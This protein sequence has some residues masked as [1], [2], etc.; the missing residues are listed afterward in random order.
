[1][2]ESLC[3]GFVWVCARKGEGVCHRAVGVGARGRACVLG[4]AGGKVTEKDK[5]QEGAI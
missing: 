4:V 3:A 5:E 1:M 2:K